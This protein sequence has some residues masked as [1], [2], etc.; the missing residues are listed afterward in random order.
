MKDGLAALP[1]LPTLAWHVHGVH[2][3]LWNVQPVI[4]QHCFQL[5]QYD[6]FQ[7]KT[8]LRGNLPRSL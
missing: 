7:V 5:S 3:N 2:K 8:R 4:S 6:Y 1:Q